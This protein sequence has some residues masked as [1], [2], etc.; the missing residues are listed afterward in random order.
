MG[1]QYLPLLTWTMSRVDTKGSVPL[2]ACRLCSE[3]KHNFK[4]FL[5]EKFVILPSTL[6][7]AKAYN[8]SEHPFPYL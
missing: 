6:T 4:R 7:L 3:F 8:L 5:K 2:S 1:A